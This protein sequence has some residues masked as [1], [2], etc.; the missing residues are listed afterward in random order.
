MNAPN[1]RLVARF[2]AARRDPALVVIEGFH[3]LKHALRFGA[4]ILEAVSRDPET[5]I[6]LARRL[7]PDVAPSLAAL[8]VPVPA[9]LF[10]ELAPRPPETGVLALARRPDVDGMR[11]LRA[12]V[13]PLVLLDRPAHARNLGAAVR[14][15][16]AAGA[17]ALLTLGPLDPWH[18]T[19]V[20]AGAGLQFALPVARIAELGEVGRPIVAFD[21]EGDLLEPA[22]IPDDAILVFGS[23]RQGLSPGLLA[24]ADR[25]VRLPMRPGVSSLNL[26]TAVA[27]V[28]YLQRLRQGEKGR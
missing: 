12:G 28:L 22:R 21:P 2:R 6:D 1:G 11:Y 19:A 14:V 4:E 13:E 18:P 20:R 8:L 27:A 24:R 7:A 25:R 10:A 23:E 15:A 17:D 9:A 3:A 16:A 26:A 5:A